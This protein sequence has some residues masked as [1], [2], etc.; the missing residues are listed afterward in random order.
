MIFG[1]NITKTPAGTPTQ[2]NPAYGS[3]QVLLSDVPDQGLYLNGAN[4]MADPPTITE[5]LRVGNDGAIYERS[6]PVAMGDWIT[7]PYTPAMLTAAAGTWT[8]TAPNWNYSYALVGKLMVVNIYM[9]GPTSSATGWLR[10]NMPAGFVLA[11]NFYCMY[12]AVPTGQ[13]AE[14]LVTV[15]P[16]AFTCY[17]SAAAGAWGAVAGAIVSLQLSFWVN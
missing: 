13:W 6:R 2:P 12:A 10:V 8:V 15:A 17:A 4:A 1:Q 5:R 11:D 7:V 14:G 3:T 9:N 16:N